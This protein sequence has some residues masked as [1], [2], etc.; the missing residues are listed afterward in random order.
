MDALYLPSLYYPTL[1]RDLIAV[2]TVVTAFLLFSKIFQIERE[3]WRRLIINEKYRE[4]YRQ[5]GGRP[6]S[7]RGEIRELFIDRETPLESDQTDPDE[8]ELEDLECA[9]DPDGQIYPAA[10]KGD[11][12]PGDDSYIPTDDRLFDGFA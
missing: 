10:G 2:F 5:A 7:D 8:I 1:R 9:I 4:K 11:L 12:D 3:Q 6:N